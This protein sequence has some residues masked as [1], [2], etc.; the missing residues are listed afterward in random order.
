MRIIKESVE[1]KVIK[2]KK[3]ETYK[4][5]IDTDTNLIQIVKH[6]P[7]DLQE[8][9]WARQIAD[10]RWNIY[11]GNNGQL[12]STYSGDSWVGVVNLL[13]DLDENSGYTVRID[14]T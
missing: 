5:R 1:T 9:H 6:S 2:S 12:K 7:Y 13:S 10:N 11:D 4:V 8:Y 14:R 3:R